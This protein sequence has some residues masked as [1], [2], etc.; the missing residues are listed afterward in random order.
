MGVFKRQ[1]KIKCEPAEDKS[2]VFRCAGFE[3]DKKVAYIEGRPDESGGFTYT[4]PI[5]G[6]SEDIQQLTKAI[7]ERVRIKKGAVRSQSQGDISPD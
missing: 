5:Q 4:G 1:L 2:G 7:A 6:T 3:D